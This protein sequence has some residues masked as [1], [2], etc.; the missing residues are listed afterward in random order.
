MTMRVNSHFSQKVNKEITLR[1]LTQLKFY[2][3][4][5]NTTQLIK[6]ARRFGDMIMIK[7]YKGK[8]RPRNHKDSTG[9]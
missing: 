5:V 7:V 4:N 8:S 6:D 1:E 3:K 9:N 2:S